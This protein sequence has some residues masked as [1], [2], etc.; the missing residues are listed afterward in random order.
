MS[1]AVARNADNPVRP[2]KPANFTNKPVNL[3]KAMN[4]IIARNTYRTNPITLA[5]YLRISQDDGNNLETLSITNQ[6]DLVK[7]FIASH[8]DFTDAKIVEY[9]DDGISGSHTDR[10]AY[11]RLMNDVENGLIDCIVVKDLSRIGRNLIDVD[12]LLMNHLVTLNVRFVAINNGYDS[13]SSPLSNLELAVINLANQHYNRDLAQKS[14]TARNTKSKNGE[15][16][17]TQAPFGYKKCDK[18]KNKLVPDDEAAGY[19]RIIFSLACEGKKT[20]EIAKILNTQGI[21]SP[22]VYKKSKGWADVWHNVIDPDHCFWTSG[23]VYKLLKHEVYIGSVVANRFKTI[24]PSSKRVATRPREEWII[25]PNAHEALVSEEDFNKAQL[26][27]VK[28]RYHD[29]PGHI[30]GNKVKCP[31]CGHAMTRYTKNNPRFKCG[32]VKVTDH[33]GCKTH[34][35]QQSEIERNVIPAIKAHADVLLD[36]EEMKL[37]QIKKSKATTKSLEAKIATEQ[38]SIEALE[39]QITK[40]FTSLASGKITQE[41]FL[42]KKSSINDAI[43]RKQLGIEKSAE[44]LRN[45]TE[46]RVRSEK[47]VAELKQFLVLEK[48]DRDI[49]NL[50]VDKILVHDE[51]DIEI[52]W[53][54]GFGGSGAGV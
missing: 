37:A 12:D 53:C 17:T 13:F 43:E 27:T 44:Q 8:A 38:K 42:Q 28:K 9:V 6:R 41:V 51:K 14:I 3:G 40:I 31:S 19:V 30:F 1:S 32:T 22:S 26:V 39:A 33:Y 7:N 23:V 45:L 15:Y 25:A 48:L 36:Y 50:L 11:K 10:E 16:L 21:P 54:G 24:A 35:I 49:V 46:G 20:T 52:V 29:E 2:N 18:V 34:T 5:I 47:V 4:V